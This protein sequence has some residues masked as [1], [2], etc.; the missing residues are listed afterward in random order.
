MKY[1]LIIFSLLFFSFIKPHPR[2]LI[3]TK[4]TGYHHASIPDGVAAIEKLGKE[5]GFDTDTTSNSELFTL[6]NLKKYAAVVFVSTTG[7]LF[8]EDQ[9]TALVNYMKSGGGY[10]GIHAAADAEYKWPWY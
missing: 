2:V 5:H 3:F 4:T 1:T 8:N 7:D 9:K 10:V 6:K